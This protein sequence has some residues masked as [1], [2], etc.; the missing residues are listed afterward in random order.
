MPCLSR[1]ELNSIWL[2]CGTTLARLGF[3]RQ[4]MVELISLTGRFKKRRYYKPAVQR[5]TSSYNSVI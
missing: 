5:I 1:A 4:A 2:D 3:K